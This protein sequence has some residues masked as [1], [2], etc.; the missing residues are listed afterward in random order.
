MVGFLGGWG[1][2]I[3]LLVCNRGFWQTTW[4]TQRDV[5]KKFQISIFT[6]KCLWIPAHKC[7]WLILFSKSQS[8][9]EGECSGLAPWGK[10]PP[11]LL[12]SS[13]KIYIISLHYLGLIKTKFFL[14]WTL[15]IAYQN[16]EDIFSVSVKAASTA[17]SKD[18]NL[19]HRVVG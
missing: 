1:R 14:R 6:D 18:K 15:V 13:H 4:D 19:T 10:F 2:I 16:V 3:C 5:G 17:A 8:G 7:Y 11:T 12:K 9:D